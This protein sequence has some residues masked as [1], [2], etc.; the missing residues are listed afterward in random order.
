MKKFVPEDEEDDD[1]EV[2]EIIHFHRGSAHQPLHKKPK[3]E[4]TL[5]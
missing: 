5:Y 2:I 1:D 3:L 4:E